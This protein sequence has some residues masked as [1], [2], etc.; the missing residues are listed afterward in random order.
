M[1]PLAWVALGVAAAIVLA[2]IAYAQPDP[3]DRR[4]RASDRL[5]DDLGDPERPPRR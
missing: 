1:T 5:A 2:M 3:R 4:R